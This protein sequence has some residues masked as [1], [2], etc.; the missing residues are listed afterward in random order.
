MSIRL[1]KHVRWCPP[2]YREL[3]T[4][5]P[6]KHASTEW[7]VFELDD[8][9]PCFLWLPYPML[10]RPE[11]GRGCPGYEPDFPWHADVVAVSREG[12]GTLVV[13]DMLV[14]V[15]VSED[16]NR[17]KVIDLDQLVDA[18]GRG[19]VT[20]DECFEALRVLQAWLQMLHGWQVEKDFPPKGLPTQ[21]RRR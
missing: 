10:L 8:P 17:Y 11:Y 5:T 21:Y 12:D 15:M 4:V 2:D 19:L 14:D 7:V 20:Q 18:A 3:V 9:P 1:V 6:P 13:K 16:G